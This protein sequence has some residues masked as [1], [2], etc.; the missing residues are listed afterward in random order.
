MTI[1]T[2]LT[3]RFT[4]LVS[5]ILA[6]TFASI[7]GF[8]WYYISSDFY[9]RL[10]RKASTYGELLLRQKMEPRLLRRVSQLRKDQLPDQKITVYNV[11]DVPVFMTNDDLRLGM[12]A[13]E[14]Q[15]IRKQGKRDFRWQRYYVSGIRYQVPDGDFVVLASARNVYGDRFL[16]T[17]L[18]TFGG[19]FLAIVGIVAFAGRLYAGDA[20][21]PMQQIE[22]Q[23]T[24]IFPRTMHERLRISR[25]DDEISRL[26]ATINRLLDR[27]EESF[28]LQRM[29]VANVSHELKNPLTQISSQLEVSLLNRREPEAYQRTI[30]SVLE[31]VGHLS[32][33]TLEL[34]KLSQVNDADPARLLTDTMRL[35]E[36]VWDVRDHVNNLLPAY[37][38]TVDL[39]ELPD[40]F[41]RLTVAGSTTLIRTALINLT[42]NACKF[43]SDG[44]AALRVEFEGDWVCVSVSNQGQPIPADDLPYIFQP[45]YRANPTAD[46]RGYGIGLPLVEQIVRLHQGRL[47]VRSADGEPTVFRIELPRQPDL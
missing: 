11:R 27:I 9:H 45:F 14:L 7:Y 33:L 40:D 12:P 30:R 23:L 35:D 44:Q 4:G 26:S 1:R 32:A 20:L 24:D 38:V 43:A 47:F 46:V 21:E 29:F 5:A 13:R 2:R 41:D 42:E 36:V 6:L 37:R 34:L 19:L 3:L 22:E 16:R 18:W 39:G 31:D 25:E 8:C 10:D 28:R 17:M 15:A